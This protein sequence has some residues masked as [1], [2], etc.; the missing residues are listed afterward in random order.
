MV[1]VMM[2][3]MALKLP[4]SEVFSGRISNVVNAG[5]QHTFSVSLPDFGGRALLRRRAFIHS[6]L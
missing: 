1:D 6:I 4:C 2:N 3:A 5:A